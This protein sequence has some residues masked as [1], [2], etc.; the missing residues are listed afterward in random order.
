MKNRILAH[1]LYHRFVNKKQYPR[2]VIKT[3]VSPKSLVATTYL[4]N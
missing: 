1:I 4:P 3:N 2:D